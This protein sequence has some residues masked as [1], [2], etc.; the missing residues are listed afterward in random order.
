MSP[1]PS[2]SLD[3]VLHFAALKSVGESCA[4]PLK[5]Y[6]NNVTGSANLLEVMVEFGVTKIVFSSSA[7]VYG[8]P[9]Y[10]PID[11]DHP[12]GGCTNP[13]GKTKYFMEEIMRDVAAAQPSWSCTL[14][15][16]FN[17][18]GAHPSAR[19]GE[20]PLGEPSNLMPYVAQVTLVMHKFLAT[21]QCAPVFLPQVGMGRREVLSVYGG[22]WDTVDGTG[23]R[24]YIHVMD[25]AAGHLAAVTQILG[26][27][28][29]T[30]V[31]NLGT[32]TGTTVL[33]MVKAFEAA[34]GR[35]VP[36]K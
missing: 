4:K 29:A 9:Q 16:Y 20:D 1:S 25:L 11:E 22:D 10:L 36:Y 12:I 7:T 31:Y 24:D 27:G 15:R 3:C 28:P 17:P 19:I 34:S 14:L 6:G 18:V 30:R 33:Q 21:F 13:Y 2:P 8:E 35:P 23:C 26:T 5:Y 32:G